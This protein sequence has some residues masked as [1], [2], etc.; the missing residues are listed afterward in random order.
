MCIYGDLTVWSV[1]AQSVS[2][3][4][5]F[6]ELRFGV[7]RVSVYDI[8]AWMFE[9]RKSQRDSEGLNWIQERG[10]VSLSFKH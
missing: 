8:A 4:R 3:E 1:R 2:L 5:A 7:V 6:W 10:F 9:Y